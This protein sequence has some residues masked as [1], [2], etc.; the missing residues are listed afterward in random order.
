MLIKNINKSTLL[1]LSKCNYKY[2]NFINKIKNLSTSK[3]KNDNILKISLIT[4]AN[5]RSIANK[6]KSRDEINNS[7]ELFKNKLFFKLNS[8]LS[9][10]FKIEIELIDCSRKK[11]YNKFKNSI[12]NSNIIWVIGGDTL[13]L[14]YYLKKYKFDKIIKKRILNDKIIYI[15]CSAGTII[16]GNSIDTA[17]LYRQYTHIKKYYRIK[18]FKKKYWRNNTSRKGLN[19]INNYDLL[20]HCNNNKTFKI[21]NKYI[22]CLN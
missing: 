21:K 2:N 22:K 16:L 10:N 19:L 15:G 8:I 18:T 12:E 17:F 14:M 20:P 5:Y 1:L 4:T 7:L 9:K 11:N 13:Y 6:N 3:F